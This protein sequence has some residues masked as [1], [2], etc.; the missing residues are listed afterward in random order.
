LPSL[1]YCDP[2]AAVITSGAMYA[3]VPTLDLACDCHFMDLE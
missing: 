3:A 1:L 2:R